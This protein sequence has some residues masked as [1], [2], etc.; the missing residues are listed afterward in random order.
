MQMII[1]LL[2][3]HI[4]YCEQQEGTDQIHPVGEDIIQALRVQLH[5]DG[6]YHIQ[7]AED[8]EATARCDNIKKSFLNFKI[9]LNG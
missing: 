4:R 8:D 3:Q 2:E 7:G 5:P 9:T 6:K 1:F